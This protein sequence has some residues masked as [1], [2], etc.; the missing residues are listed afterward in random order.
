MTAGAAQILLKTAAIVAARTGSCSP[1]C[2]PLLWLVAAQLLRAGAPIAALLDTTPRGRLAQALPHAPAFLASPLFRQGPRPRAPRAP[3]GARRRVRRSRSQ[4]TADD[5]GDAVAF[6]AGRAVVADRPVLLHQGVVP[7]VNL[8]GAA[9]CALEW[10]ELQACFAPAVDAWGGN[11]VAGVY[12][13]GDGAGIAGARRPAARGGSPRSASPMRWDA[14]TAAHAIRREA[15]ALRRSRDAAARPPF[16]DALYRPA[17]AFRIPKG[18]T[19]ACRCEEVSAAAIARAHARVRGSQQVKELRA[20]AWAR[21]RAASAGS[22]SPIDRARGRL[23]GTLR[24]SRHCTRFPLKPVTLAEIASL[25]ASDAARR[26][27]AR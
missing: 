9:G 13:A 20:A 4:A 17:D 18:D 11:T 6:G 1:A 12:I 26:A 3:P 22:R 27:V 23:L 7:D 14:S 21:A 19:L 10:N 15:A 2:G 24:T 16:L 8:A 5:G 25:P